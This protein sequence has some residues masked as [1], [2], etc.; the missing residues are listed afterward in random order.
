[1]NKAGFI[2][3]VKEVGNYATKKDAENAVNAFVA[4][5][6]TALAKEESVELVG[7]GKFEVVEQKGKEGKVPGSNKTYKTADKMVPKFKPGKGLKDLVS[8]AK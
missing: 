4:S 3:L 7:F 6:E 5:I 2:D 8:K 1:M